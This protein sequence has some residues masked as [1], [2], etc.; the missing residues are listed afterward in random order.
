MISKRISDDMH[1]QMKILNMFIPIQINALLQFKL[2]L[3]C[4]K[5]HKATPH[6]AKYDV[7]IDVKLFS[8]VYRRIY[9]RKFLMLSNQTSRYLAI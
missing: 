8:T 1:P 5:L 2:K 4:C 9:S 7:I 3:E 6:P